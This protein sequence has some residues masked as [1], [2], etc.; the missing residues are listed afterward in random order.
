MYR[1]IETYSGGKAGRGFNKTASIQVIESTRG[2]YF[3][4]KVYRFKIGD[5]HSKIVARNKARKYLDKLKEK[6]AK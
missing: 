1:I 4:R 6:E 2:G 5:L 3:I